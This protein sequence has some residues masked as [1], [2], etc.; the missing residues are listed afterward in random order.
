MKEIGPHKQAEALDRKDINGR[1]MVM[2]RDCETY[3]HAFKIAEAETNLS[4]TPCIKDCQ[5]CNQ[6][7]HSSSIN[8]AVPLG[9]TCN[10]LLHRCP[11]DGRMWW[12]T[13]IYFHLWQQVTSYAE[14]VALKQEQT[15]LWTST[16]YDD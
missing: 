12:Q 11:K 13:N 7:R 1:Y 16:I 15:D 9:G 3:A 14:W 5:N 4:L 10:T 8:P 2:C 6:L